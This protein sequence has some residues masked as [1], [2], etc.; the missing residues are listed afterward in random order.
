VHRGFLISFSDLEF[1]F[2]FA[3]ELSL[4]MPLSS[5]FFFLS[6]VCPTDDDRNAKEEDEVTAEK[7]KK[8]KKKTELPQTNW[9]VIPA[10]VLSFTHQFDNGDN[11]PASR[12][13][14]VDVNNVFLSSMP[15][16]V[17]SR[18]ASL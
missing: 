3:R 12:R 14:S 8:E 9:L 4:S 5:S 6:R 16:V 2:F 18:E 7:E 13:C 11:E 1:L 17:C 10:R 15:D